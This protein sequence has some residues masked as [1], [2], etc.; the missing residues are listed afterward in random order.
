[1]N[2]ESL[3]GRVVAQIAGM[4]ESIRLRREREAEEQERRRIAAE[5]RHR[6]EMARKREPIR[7]RRLISHCENWHMAADIRAFVAAVEENDH[8]LEN[9]E[10]FKVWKSWALGHAD[11]IDPLQDDELTNQHVSDCEV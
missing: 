7:F 11:R 9:R 5:E 6:A 8:A 4:Y 1:L 3:L 10:S 2:A